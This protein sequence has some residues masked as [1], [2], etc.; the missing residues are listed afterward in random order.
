MSSKPKAAV[1]EFQAGMYCCVVASLGQRQR[2]N[3]W[4]GYSKQIEINSLFKSPLLDRMATTDSC[5]K[6]SVQVLASLLQYVILAELMSSWGIDKITDII[7][8][9]ENH[10]GIRNKLILKFYSEMC[11]FS[12][13]GYVSYKPEPVKIMIQIMVD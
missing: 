9:A 1:L 12:V 8:G 13:S 4:G 6:K 2:A 3:G 7:E 5:F 11:V 10:V